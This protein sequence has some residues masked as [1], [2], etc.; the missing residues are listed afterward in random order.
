VIGERKKA[1]QGAFSLFDNPLG[2]EAKRTKRRR[3]KAIWHR[4]DASA[5]VER[6]VGGNG[7]QTSVLTTVVKGQVTRLDEKS[8][9]TSQVRK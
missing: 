2:K 7:L 4:K 3:C 8:H 1:H 5:I 9:L 6:K